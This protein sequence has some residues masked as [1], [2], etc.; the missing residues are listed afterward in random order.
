MAEATEVGRPSEA[1]PGEE[2]PRPSTTPEA[3][4]VAAEAPKDAPTDAARAST[5]LPKKDSVAATP[6]D[7]TSKPSATPAKPA[8][9]KPKEETPRASTPEASSTGTEKATGESKDSPR[10]SV[11]LGKKKE[12]KGFRVCK[13]MHEYNDD[14]D[15]SQAARGYSTVIRVSHFIR[16]CQNSTP[17]IPLTP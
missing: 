14:F 17:R 15:T 7:A 12:G 4:S 5:D 1:K 11:D 10:S 3:P 16:R 13:Y 6:S 8:E 2:T 9:P